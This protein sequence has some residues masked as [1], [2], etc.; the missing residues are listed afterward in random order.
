L[1][2]DFFSIFFGGS[3]MKKLVLMSVVALLLAPVASAEFQI[4]T[5]YWDEVGA[6]TTDW[7]TAG[8][9]RWRNGGIP[10]GHWDPG[11]GDIGLYRM[12]AKIDTAGGGDVDILIA[13]GDSVELC[14]AG[15]DRRSKENVT[16]TVQGSLTT[17]YYDSGLSA[18]SGWIVLGAG[19][20]GPDPTATATL[21]IDG[22]TVSAAGLVMDFQ[23]VSTVEIDNGGS[24]TSGEFRMNGDNETGFLNIINGTADVQDLTRL[25]GSERVQLGVDGTLKVNGNVD[26]TALI[27]SGHIVGAFGATGV[28]FAYDGGLDKTVVQG[29]P[30]PAT[31]CLLGLGGLFLARRRKC[32]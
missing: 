32:K 16:L 14:R 2:Y 29:I 13:S 8:N 15:I 12:V 21:A 20:N 10:D 24:F 9:W 3:M 5:E 4:R 27:G 6:T 7:M 31:M 30:E 25:G 22:G 18:S 26:F 17:T 19:Y 23:G 1:A 11:N 28:T